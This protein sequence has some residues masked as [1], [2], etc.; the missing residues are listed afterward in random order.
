MSTEPTIKRSG[1]YTLKIWY[2]FSELENRPFYSH[3]L[4]H[5]GKSVF[6]LPTCNKPLEINQVIGMY[7]ARQLGK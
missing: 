2:W 6:V 4:L 1:D 5:K 3:S 7:Q